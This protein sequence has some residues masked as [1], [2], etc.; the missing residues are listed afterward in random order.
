MNRKVQHKIKSE[1]AQ[2]AADTIQ[3]ILFIINFCCCCCFSFYKLYNNKKK[4]ARRIEYAQSKFFLLSASLH[5][6]GVREGARS[7]EL[8][9]SNMATVADWCAQN[10]NMQ[11]IPCYSY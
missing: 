3:F 2:N 6:I 7:V 8:K 10:N 5:E 1:T 4:S 9:K 11:F